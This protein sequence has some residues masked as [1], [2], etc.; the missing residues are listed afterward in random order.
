MAPAV[1]LT[2]PRERLR[3]LVVDDNAD[4]ARALALLLD[5]YGFEASVAFDGE[6]AVTCAGETQ[7]QI[8]ILDIGLP[9]MDGWEVARWIRR[10]PW[11]AAASLIALSGSGQDADRARSSAAGIDVH[12]VKPAD[13]AELVRLLDGVRAKVSR[14]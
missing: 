5:H 4:A 7:P 9:G 8:A 2:P 12:L 13:A 10:Q 14:S 1:P 6:S 3:V 11:G